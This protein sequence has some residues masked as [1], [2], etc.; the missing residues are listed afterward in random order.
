[1]SISAS[2]VVVD[3]IVEVTGP[4]TD[5][6]L[7]AA[8]VPISGNVGVTGS[9]AVTGPLTDAQLRASDVSVV[10]PGTVNVLT[11]VASSANLTITSLPATTST[12]ILPANASRKSAII[13]IPKATTSI[14]YGTAASAT[15][16]TYLTGA[17]NSTITVTGYTGIIVAYGAAQAINATELV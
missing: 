10:I 3:N 16:F 15:S 8:A 13:F 1:M 5:A 14:K 9:V 12:T 11:A 4:L 6:E 7:R 17:A 2:D